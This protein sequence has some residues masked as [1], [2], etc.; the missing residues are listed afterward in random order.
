MRGFWLITKLRL[1][2]FSRGLLR[3]KSSNVAILSL[4]VVAIFGMFAAFMSMYIPLFIGLSKISTQ[5]TAISFTTLMLVVAVMFLI[6]LTPTISN[7]IF[8]PGGAIHFFAYLPVERSVLIASSLISSCVSA[9]FPL[10]IFIAIT[11]AYLIACPTIEALIGILAI[12]FLLVGISFLSSNVLLSLGQRGRTSRMAK[13]ALM[14]NVIIYF[15]IWSTVNKYIGSNSESALK[16]LAEQLMSRETSVIGRLSAIVTD[17]VWAFISLGIGFSVLA[18]SVRMANSVEISTSVSSIKVRGRKR[19]KIKWSLHKSP[20]LFR[21]SVAAIRDGQNFLLIFGPA[22]FLAIM[23]IAMPDRAKM[24]SIMWGG[25]IA[26]QYVALISAKLF[27]LDTKARDLLCAAPV[28]WRKVIIQRALLLTSV[29]AVTLIIAGLIVQELLMHPILTVQAQA[30]LIICIFW[31]SL[32]GQWR[33]LTHP[34]RDAIPPKQALGLVMILY[35]IV[36]SLLLGAASLPLLKSEGI[37]YLKVFNAVAWL[38][39]LAAFLLAGISVL[40]LRE[41]KIKY[42]LER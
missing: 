4:A 2:S 32:W 8:A 14:I 35:Y 21:D 23:S 24:S 29:V 3:T 11:A 39:V 31:V 5:A 12:F 20:F 28:V 27:S 9:F 15:L 34:Q 22:I 40:K 41:D 33:W 7:E 13:W 6:Q 37:P 26:V 10:I 1:K 38:S 25:M 19:A 30:T 18:L 36:V 17:P 42:W 16:G